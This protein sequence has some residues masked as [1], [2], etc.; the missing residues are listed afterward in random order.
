MLSRLTLA[1]QYALV[2]YQARTHRRTRKT[3]FFAIAMHLVAAII[4]LVIA[5]VATEDSSS[6]FYAIWYAVGIIEMIVLIVHASLSKTLTFEGTHFNER[7]N[8]LTLIIL[9]EG[10]L[11][12]QYYVSDSNS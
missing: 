12:T 3:L 9:G 6:V 2:L 11:L 7:L 8:L 5:F 10:M 4:Y 1:C